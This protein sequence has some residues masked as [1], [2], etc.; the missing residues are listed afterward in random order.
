MLVVFFLDSPHDLQAYIN[1][2]CFFLFF[3]NQMFFITSNVFFLYATF[4]LLNRSES[5][6]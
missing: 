6:V 2:L 3:Q 1:L 4:N 5:V